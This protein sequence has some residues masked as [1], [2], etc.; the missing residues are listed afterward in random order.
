LSA[1]SRRNALLGI[2]VTLAT[3]PIAAAMAA[4]V[5]PLL[6]VSIIPIFAVAP[7]FA[8]DRF[9]FFSAEGVATTTQSIQGG[10]VGIPGLVSGSFDVLYSNAVSVLTAL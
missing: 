10:A 8:A 6:R 2:G 3:P 9:G 7:Q 1:V 4:D 5:L